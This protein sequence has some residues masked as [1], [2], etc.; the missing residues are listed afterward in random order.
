MVT[1]DG[2]GNPAIRVLDITNPAAVQEITGTVQES[3]STYTVSSTSKRGARTAGNLGDMSKPA[4]LAP[5]ALP[6]G[7]SPATVRTS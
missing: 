6:L 3:G 1:I 7:A 2:F 5:H 4:S